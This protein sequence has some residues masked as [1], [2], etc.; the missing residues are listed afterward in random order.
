MRRQLIA[1]LTPLIKA[2]ENH[3]S[4][5][6]FFNFTRNLLRAWLILETRFFKETGFSLLTSIERDGYD[7]STLIDELLFTD[8]E[9]MKCI[10]RNAVTGKRVYQ[11][12]VAKKTFYIILD[13][14]TGKADTAFTY[15]AAVRVA[16]D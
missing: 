8:G 12:T 5:R 13:T 10:I 2:H 11:T 4:D 15:D 1:I 9:I 16:G 7:V 3:C 14:R 6:E